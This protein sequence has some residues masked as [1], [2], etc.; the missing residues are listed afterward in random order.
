MAEPPRSSVSSPLTITVDADRPWQGVSWAEVRSRADLFR[1][2]AL[3]D[4]KVRYRQAVLGVAWALLRPLAMVTVFVVLFGLLDRTPAA[5]GVP[6][7]A[8]ALVGLLA[9]QLFSSSV[10]DQSDSLVKNRAMLSKV[11]FP[12]VLVPLAAQMV[13]LVDYAVAFVP[14][15]VWLWWCGVT[16]TSAVVLTPLWVL[17]VVLLSTGLGLVLCSLQA[18]YRDVGHVVPIALQLLFFASP[19][20][21]E[22]TALIPEPYQ[23]WYRLNPLATLLDGLRWSLVGSPPPAWS[24]VAIAAIGIAVLLMAAWMVFHALDRGLVDRL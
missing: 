21:Y 19:V 17:G 18:R 16:W 22:T 7:A 20:C 9:W 12:R 14:A 15:L 3:R 8:S 2:L 1:M 5:E 6:Y 24:A 4:L 23:S 13:S 11:Y 10:L